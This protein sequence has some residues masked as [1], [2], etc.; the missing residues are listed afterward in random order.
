MQL[1]HLIHV[2]QLTI[3]YHSWANVHVSS[4]LLNPRTAEVQL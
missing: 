2:D 1:R 4:S 3:E